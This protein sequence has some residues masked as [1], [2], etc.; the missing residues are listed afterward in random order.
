MNSY[1]YFNDESDLQ[2][3]EKIDFS[4]NGRTILE[5]RYLRRNKLGEI[6]ETPEDMFQRV[7]NAIAEPDEPYRNPE[8]TSIEFYNLISTKKFFPNSPT[9]TGAGT[10]IG[11]LAACFVLPVEDDL[12]KSRDGIFQT[13]RNAALIQQSGGGNGFSFS[14][15]RAKGSRIST[16][17]GLSTG[18]VGFMEA[19]NGA[20][21]VIAQ[22]GVRKGA[23]MGILRVDHPDIREFITAK[24]TEGKLSNFNISVALT[25]KFLEAVEKD[26][27]YEIFDPHTKEIVE[28]PKA[29]EIFDLIVENAYK[30]G[31]P[32][33]LFIDTANKDNPVPSLYELEATNPCGEQWL[34]PYENCCLGSINLSEHITSDNKIDW[35]ELRKTVILSTRFLDNVVSANKYVPA[36]PQLKEAAHQNRRIGL[37]IMGLADLFYVL[38]VRYGSEEAQDLAGQVMEFI[39]FHAMKASIEL[40]KERGPFPAIKDSIF[41]P[42][43]L[44]WT[45]P[46]P[47][48]SFSFGWERPAIDWSEITNGIRLYGLRNAAVTTVAPTGTISTVA[49]VEGYGCE[50]VFALAYLRNVYQAAGDLEKMTLTYVSPSFQKALDDIDMSDVKRRE[51]IDE[52]IRVGSCQS[53]KDL[54]DDLRHTFVVSGDITPEEHIYMQASLQRFVD[55]SISKTCNLPP[56]AVPEDVEKVYMMGW[57]LGCKGLTVYVSGSRQEEVL[58]TQEKKESTTEG[59]KSDGEKPVE[60]GKID[61]NKDVSKEITNNEEKL[62]VEKPSD[63]KLEREY[64]LN[65]STY[66]VKTPQGKAFITINKDS[67]GRPFEVFINVGKAGTDVSALSEGLGRLVSGWLRVPGASENAVTEIIS[68]LGGI[69]GSRSVGFGK[70]KVSS[71]PDAVAK[72]LSEELGYSLLKNQSNGNGDNFISTKIN[73]ESLNIRSDASGV[74]LNPVTGNI[75][76]CPDCGNYS[77]IKEEGCAKCYLCGYSV[78]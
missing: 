27:T 44:V 33:V 74:S 5:K 42:S 75:D 4:E 3:N 26:E 22:G 54:P 37:G 32:G 47:L 59:G 35:E 46:T 29:R 77:F 39:R 61:A 53:I 51:I 65:G 13:L 2:K 16:S 67:N 66:C 64:R 9:F 36:V 69:G 19:Y 52:I 45:P 28:T 31:E 30:N 41:N 20:F 6:E 58:V 14:R 21:G 55:N 7:A 63:V 40:A 11:Q 12:G 15:L 57:K 49:G 23:N 8:K 71:I 56:T 34:G 76:V 73:T 78:C 17:N 60:E 68:Q 43:N 50:P 48:K 72:V 18:P 25:D 38:G 10:P 24:T 1:L 62:I 70:N